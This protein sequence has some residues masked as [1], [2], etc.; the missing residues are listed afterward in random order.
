M[1]AMSAVAIGLLSSIDR[2]SWL[3]WNQSEFGLA[4][5]DVAHH[6]A[7]EDGVFFSPEIDPLAAHSETAA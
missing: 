4:S 1:T 5:I 2:L 6:I 3:G 7:V